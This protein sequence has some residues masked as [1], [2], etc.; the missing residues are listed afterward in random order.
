MAKKGYKCKGRKQNGQLKTG[1]TLR[2][3]RVV[4]AKTTRKC[5][6]KR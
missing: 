5:Y 6:E 3:G 4:R 1:D 2:N